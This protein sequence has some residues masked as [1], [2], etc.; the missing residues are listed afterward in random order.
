ML[1]PIQ[2]SDEVFLALDPYLPLTWGVSAFRANRFGANDGVFWP[3]LFVVLATGAGALVVGTPAG[4]RRVLP[5][6]QWLAAA[7]H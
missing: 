5:V 6:D 2:L 4:R 3:Q 7:G 1:L